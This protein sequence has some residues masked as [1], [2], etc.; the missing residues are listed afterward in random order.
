M[1]PNCVLVSLQI[2]YNIMHV[3]CPYSPTVNTQACA[4]AFRISM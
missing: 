1:V 2:F 4:G 3:F